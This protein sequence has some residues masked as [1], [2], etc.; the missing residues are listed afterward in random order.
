MAFIAL[1]LSDF[2][3]GANFQHINFIFVFASVAIRI[4]QAALGPW[5]TKYG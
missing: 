1:C 2:G 3:T 4:L 5:E